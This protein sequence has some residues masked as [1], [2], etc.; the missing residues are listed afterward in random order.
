MMNVKHGNFRF[1][2]RHYTCG[3][4]HSFYSCRGYSHA[5]TDNQNSDGCNFSLIIHGTKINRL[6]VG[7]F[8]DQT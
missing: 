7:A 2:F 5:V 4:D 3:R 1:V 8:Q 6:W